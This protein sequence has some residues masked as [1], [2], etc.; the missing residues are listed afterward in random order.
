MKY[1]RP[2]IYYSNDITKVNFKKKKYV[3]LKGQGQEIKNYS[4]NRKVM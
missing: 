2:I 4:T 1:E 3:K